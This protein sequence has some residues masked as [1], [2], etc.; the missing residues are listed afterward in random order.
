[1]EA[2]FMSTPV[3]QKVSIRGRKGETHSK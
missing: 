2:L 3:L 1:M